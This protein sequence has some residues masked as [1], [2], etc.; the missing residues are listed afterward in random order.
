MI[1]SE[2]TIKIKNGLTKDRFS[3]LKAIYDMP[4]IQHKELSKKLGKSPNN[5]SNMISKISMLEFELIRTDANGT[6]KYYFLTDLATQYVEQEQVTIGQ[7]SKDDV[8]THSKSAEAVIGKLINT[9]NLFK[10]KCGSNWHSELTSFFNGNGS[11]ADDTEIGKIYNDMLMQL[12]GCRKQDTD[13]LQ[14]LFDVLED[15]QL[16]DQITKYL[17]EKF[18]YYDLL[19][20]LLVP[21]RADN[22]TRFTII[23]FVFSELHPIIFPSC[24]DKLLPET[25]L[26]IHEHNNLLIGIMKLSNE[27]CKNHYS[28]SIAVEKW[29]TYFLTGEVAFYIAEKCAVLMFLHRLICPNLRPMNNSTE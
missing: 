19:K 8:F 2:E 25:L 29:N 26:T 18:F 5:L 27:F 21:V 20:P 6:E 13:I 15:E 10:N 14:R 7:F 16:S 22:I 17:N 4:G 3:I 24:Q 28:K 1:T 11:V 12:H 23:D 9:I